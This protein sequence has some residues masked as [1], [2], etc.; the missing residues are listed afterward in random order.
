MGVLVK[1]FWSGAYKAFHDND[2]GTTGLRV[3]AR[4]ALGLG[5]KLREGLGL[6]WASMLQLGVGVGVGIRV[7]FGVRVLC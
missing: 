3:K 2:D 1:Y 5:L 6:R 4:M 7:T